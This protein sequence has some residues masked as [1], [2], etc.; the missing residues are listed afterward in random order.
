MRRPGCEAARGV[1]R[2]RGR[3]GGG[4]GGA[5]ATR[6]CGAARRSGRR[7]AGGRGRGVGGGRGR[8][9]HLAQGGAELRHAR[10][11][12]QAVVG[13]GVA[14]EAEDGEG[15]AAGAAAE[16]RLRAGVGDAVEGDVHVLQARV[17]PHRAREQRG[18]LVAEQVVAQDHA[19]ERA[20]PDGAQLRVPVLR[21]D[22]GAEVLNVCVV[23]EAV[24]EDQGLD[25]R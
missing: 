17:A 18:A 4:G 7:R 10:E 25:P 3:A 8:A 14:A 20:G 1:G 22:G 6:R 21:A 16:D 12:A 2:A 19:A 24:F 5:H 15:L 9:G 13:D 23:E 11:R